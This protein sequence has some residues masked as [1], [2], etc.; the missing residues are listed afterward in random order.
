MNF[1]WQNHRLAVWLVRLVGYPSGQRGQTVNLL[2]YAFDGS[3]PSPTTTFEPDSDGNAWKFKWTNK[4]ARIHDVNYH[5]SVCGSFSGG[6]IIPASPHAGGAMGEAGY[7]SGDF[8]AGVPGSDGGCQ[9]R[10]DAGLALGV[11]KII[12]LASTRA[13][14]G[15]GAVCGRVPSAGF[16]LLLLAHPQPQNPVALAFP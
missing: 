8:S 11:R 2:A 10:C 14:A 15:L 4:A 5:W 12:W 6:K 7:Q 9:T 3:N 16:E 13:G 1:I